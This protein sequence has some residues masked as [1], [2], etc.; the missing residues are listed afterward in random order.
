M[1]LFPFTFAL[2]AWASLPAAMAA[3]SAAPLQVTLTASK[4][5]VQANGA[6]RLLPAEAMRAGDVIE[7]QAVYQNNGA[8]SAR[9]VQATLPIPVGGL[10]HLP[11]AARPRTIRASLDGKRFESIPLQ[12]TVSLASGKKELQLVPA[13]EYRFLRWDLGDIAA[14]RSVTVSSRMRLSAPVRPGAQQ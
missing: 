11:D 10:E 14:G 13:S 4:V 3:N 7:Y 12:R 9:N 2:A 5:I 6:E 1:K 8:V